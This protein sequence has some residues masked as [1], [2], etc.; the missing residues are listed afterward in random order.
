MTRMIHPSGFSIAEL[1]TALLI[2]ALLAAIALPTWHQH[3]LRAWRIEARTELAAAML[4]F[5]RHALAHATY[6]SAHGTHGPAGHWPR[7]IPQPPAA[8][9]HWLTATTCG[10]IDLAHCVELR[11]TPVFA[12]PRC[13]T[14]VLRSNGQWLSSQTAAGMPTRMPHGC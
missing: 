13:G 14:L 10:Q 12:D 6:A 1:I 8:P 3:R 11:A 5:E 2:V 7:A 9:R 4:A